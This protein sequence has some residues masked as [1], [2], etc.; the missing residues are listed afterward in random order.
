MTPGFIDS[1]DH[2]HE[3]GY[4]KPSHG[5]ELIPFDFDSL[6]EGEDLGELRVGARVYFDVEGGLAGIMATR[7]RRVANRAPSGLST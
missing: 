2:D 3:R 6:A 7:V 4:I 1:I 5:G